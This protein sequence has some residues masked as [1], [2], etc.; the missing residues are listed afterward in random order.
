[1]YLWGARYR[2]FIHR[3]IQPLHLKSSFHSV[4]SIPKNTPVRTFNIMC[5]HFLSLAQIMKY[6]FILFIHHLS[7]LFIFY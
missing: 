1:M 5:D 4:F 6:L 3:G 2:L 7:D